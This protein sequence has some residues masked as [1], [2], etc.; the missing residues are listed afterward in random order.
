MS[1]LDDITALIRLGTDAIAEAGK[2]LDELKAELADH[3]EIDT[4]ATDALLAEFGEKD[5]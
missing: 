5:S 4:S 3:P 1:L 2:K